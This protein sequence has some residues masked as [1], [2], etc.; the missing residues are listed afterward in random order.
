[1]PE[2]CAII[3]KLDKI[4]KMTEAT[5]PAALMCAAGGVCV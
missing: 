2:K 1:M 3:S 4:C 5:P